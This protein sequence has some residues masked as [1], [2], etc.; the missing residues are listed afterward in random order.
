MKFRTE[1]TPPPA[2][3]QI[4]PGDKIL[5]A[6]S[7][8]A[9]N[10]A[11]KLTS[12]RWQILL[13]PHGILFNPASVDHCIQ[14]IGEKK[15]YTPADLFEADGTFH[16]FRHHGMYSGTDASNVCSNINHHISLASNYIK[17]AQW[18]ILSYGTAW[19]YRLLSS[20]EIVSN[21]HKVP[22]KKF[23][24]ELLSVL[25]LTEIIQS[26]IIALQNMNPD[27]RIIITVSPVRY[28]RDGFVEN[29][30]SKAHLVTAVHEVLERQRGVYY[31]PAYELFLDDLRDYRFTKEDLVHPNNQA[32]DY[33]WDKFE[34]SYFTP[35][36]LLFNADMQTL[37]NMKNHRPL[38]PE[39]RHY[40]QFQN[41]IS[42]L[43]MHLTKK[44]PFLIGKN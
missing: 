38:Y 19:I 35:E 25:Q 20:G 13:N 31:F 1:L 43:E 7:C 24:K 29:A 4:K 17:E 3:A 36:A 39:T 18:C 28:L 9:E 32:I 22:Q 10:I 14:D 33:I 2:S 21:C 6:G 44:Y 27:I 37:A 16:S 8:F 11:S 12:L 40:Q 42:E 30:R 15:S 34:K 41:K 5:L 26:T 23:T